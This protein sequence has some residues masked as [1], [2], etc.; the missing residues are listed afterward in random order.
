MNN[1]EQAENNTS[2][3]EIL[4]TIDNHDGLNANTN[5]N[6]NVTDNVNNV[7]DNKN[8]KESSNEN[9]NKNVNENDNENVNENVNAKNEENHSVYNNYSGFYLM[10]NY[11]RNNKSD[12]PETLRNKC[13]QNEYGFTVA[14]YWIQI[15]CNYINKLIQKGE[16]NN[17]VPLW[18]RHNPEIRDNL[19]WTIAMHWVSIFKCDV[20]LWMRHDPLLQNSNGKTIAMLYL[21]VALSTHLSL[22][23][24]TLNYLNEDTFLPI[25]MRHDNN[26]YDKDGNS[27]INYWLEYTT[28]D[29]PKWM[30]SDDTNNIKN[31]NGETIAMS[32]IIHR[33][34]LPP[35]EY[36]CEPTLKTSYNMT[37]RDICNKVIPNVDLPKW[38]LSEHENLNENADV[39]INKNVDVNIDENLNENIDEI[40]NENVDVNISKNLNVNID[41]I[42]DEK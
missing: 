21:T 31:L 23:T 15:M 33:K 16:I 18:M 13:L 10:V 20:P 17:T 37:I 3:I 1:H 35:E 14:T 38:M 7:N 25:W 30:L 34:S 19:D 8:N 4:N 36:K 32:W 40:S 26:V 41:E 39:N 6:V 11:I 9:L 5:E 24:N 42:S 12:V 27:I 29:I 28:F 2:I 22:A